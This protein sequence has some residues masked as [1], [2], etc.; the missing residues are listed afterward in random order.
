MSHPCSP[1]NDRLRH[2]VRAAVLGFGLAGACCLPAQALAAPVSQ[3]QQIDWNIPAGPLAVALDQMARQGGLNLSFDAN[4]LQGKTTGGVRGHYDSA[5]ALSIL[6]QGSDVQVQQQND[7][8]FLLIP[9]MDVGSALELGATSISSNRLGE[10]TEHSGSYTTGAVT[11]GKAPQSLRRTPQSV[12]VVTRQRID[13]Q[14]IT[15]LTNLLE[16]TPGVVVNLTDSERVQYYSRGYAIDAIQYDGA[17]VVQSSG[18]GSFIQSDSAIIDRA[19]ILR[20]ATGMLRGAGNPSGTVNL[21]RKRPTYEFQGEGSVTLGSWDAQRYVA[22]LSGPLTETGNVRGR[23]I[24]VHDD[25]DHF[26]DSRM[27][28]KEVFYGVLAF[29]LNDSTTLTTGLEWTKLDA[30]G[31]WGNL[32]ADYDGSPLPLG[33][34]TYLG[35]DWNRWDR[36]NLQ[37]FAELEHRFDNDWKL[38]LMA[39]RTHFELDD[40]GFKQTYFTRASGADNP[41]NNPYLMNYQVT[42]GDGGESLQNN[43]SATLNGPFELFGRTHELMLGVERIRNDSYAS[44]THF[45]PS[46]LFDIRDWDPKTSLPEPDIDITAH[47]VRTRTTQEGAY[48]TWRISLA[49]PLTAIIGARNNWYDYEQENNTSGNGTFSV[50]NKLVPYA[51]LIYD[52]NE[53]FSAYASYTEIFNPQTVTDVSGSVLKP[54]E[55][56]AYETGIKGEFYD[57]RLNAS[58][59]FFRIYQVGNA[60]D[61]IASGMPCGGNTGYCKIAAGKNRSQ[62]F[63]LEISGEVLPGWNVTGGYTYNT[64]EYLN[65][66]NNQGNAIR[67]TDPK[68]MLK[69]FTSYRLPGELDAWTIGGGVQAQSDIYSRATASSRGVNPDAVASQSGYAVYNAMVNYRFNEHYSLQL[70]ANNIFDKK[71]YRQVAPTPTGYYWGDP[72][73]VSVTLRGSF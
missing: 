5:Q 6:L 59:A 19:E 57:G 72:R 67:T 64:T 11:I 17:T 48:A 69:L 52:L 7:K 50:D 37:T 63:E 8:S 34:S 12:T 31:A 23:V 21:V 39:Q 25:K 73:N 55:G 36:S 35:A 28:R 30:T 38:K 29:D 54:V 15:N 56:E 41:T 26:Q 4:S 45:T 13:D 51:A 60:I 43:L 61:D 3:G 42:E 49:D 27:E 62:G 66:P 46:G 47:P 40:H 18:G 33:R 22:D 24:A 32:P 16:Q 44:A 58:L 70:N 14:N 68:R 65:D 2:A 1:H 53:N 10:T 71:Y 9:A 20:G